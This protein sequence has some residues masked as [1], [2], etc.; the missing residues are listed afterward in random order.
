LPIVKLT[1]SLSAPWR[2]MVGV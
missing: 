1:L 2:R